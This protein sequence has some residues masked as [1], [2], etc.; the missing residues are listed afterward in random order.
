MCRQ[1]TPHPSHDTTGITKRPPDPYGVSQNKS[2]PRTFPKQR[3]CLVAR[4]LLSHHGTLPTDPNESHS[5]VRRGI[6][7]SS[8]FRLGSTVRHTPPEVAPFQSSC[9]G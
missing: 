2:H 9:D 1:H 8:A 7:S 6:P 3:R 4:R 5:R